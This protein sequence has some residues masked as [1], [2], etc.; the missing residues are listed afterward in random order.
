VEVLG[1]RFC[2]VSGAAEE[3]AAF[4]GEGLGLPQ[5]EREAP[6]AGGDFIGAVFPAGGASW[7]E[8]WPEGPEMPEGVMLQILVDDADA[9]AER[10]RAGGL[11]PHG[12]SDAHGE[13]CY[14][15]EAPGGLA[16]TLQSRL[17]EPD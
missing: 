5:L 4:L 11:E 17:A 8:L 9:W 10:A 2:S 1:I 7:I 13:R 14:F 15:L 16:I 3:L 12:P 6:D